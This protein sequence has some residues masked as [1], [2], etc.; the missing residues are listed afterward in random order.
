MSMTGLNRLFLTN[1]LPFDALLIVCP[2]TSRAKTIH[3]ILDIMVAELADLARTFR[4]R[5]LRSLSQI[6]ISSMLWV[7]QHGE[8]LPD[9]RKDMV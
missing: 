2:S 5:S 6:T 4:Q 9:S 8:L 1:V 3:V 7:V